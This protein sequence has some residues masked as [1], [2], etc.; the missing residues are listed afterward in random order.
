MVMAM[1]HGLMLYTAV[2]D[3]AQQMQSPLTWFQKW[4]C[5]AALSHWLTHTAECLLCSVAGT[6]DCKF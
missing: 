1:R 5:A 2:F 6:L 4:P 3:V